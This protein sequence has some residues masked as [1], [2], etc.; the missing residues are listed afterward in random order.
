MDTTMLADPV[1]AAIVAFVPVLVMYFKKFL[2]GLPRVVVW[3]MPMV[4]GGLVTFVAQAAAGAGPGTAK[5]VV[6]GALG[7]VLRELVTTVKEHGLN[8]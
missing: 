5:G 4:L 6:L 3:A 1:N 8:G 7:L 2:P